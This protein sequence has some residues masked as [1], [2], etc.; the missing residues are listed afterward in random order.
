M[1]RL[2]SVSETE[3]N[4]LLG[5]V[6]DLSGFD[7][8]PWVTGPALS[9]RRVAIITTSGLHRQADRPFGAG[10]ADADYRVIPGTSAPASW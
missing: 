10:G 6:N 5:K 8:R 9:K 4:Y 2:A 3:R 7:G 1:V